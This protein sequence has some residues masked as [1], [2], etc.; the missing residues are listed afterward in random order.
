MG[1]DIPREREG[2][3]DREGERERERERE[4]KKKSKKTSSLKDC[5]A[6]DHVDAL[7]VV[8]LEVPTTEMVSLQV[9][10]GQHRNVGIQQQRRRPGSKRNH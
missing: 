5:P 2:E 8:S 1:Q 3:R 4:R 6:T 10:V 9:F 7:W